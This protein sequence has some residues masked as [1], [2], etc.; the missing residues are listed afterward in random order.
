MFGMENE[1]A[2]VQVEGRERVVEARSYY[3][4]IRPKNA[5]S[6]SSM[7]PRLRE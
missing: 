3:S 2:R 6:S 5:S 1:I 4:S 7:R